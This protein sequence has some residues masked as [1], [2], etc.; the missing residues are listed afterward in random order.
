MLLS[1]DSRARHA[2]FM[3]GIAIVS[4]DSW[5][6]SRGDGRIV[7]KAS[8]RK[9]NSRETPPFNAGGKLLACVSLSSPPP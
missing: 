2:V 6:R 3:G 1:V 7:T 9:N 4:A 5:G 8:Q